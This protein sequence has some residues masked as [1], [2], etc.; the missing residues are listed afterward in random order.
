M[1]A[2]VTYRTISFEPFATEYCVMCLFSLILEKTITF[3][4]MLIYLSI[5]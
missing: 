3:S 4:C 1:A 5:I 2:T